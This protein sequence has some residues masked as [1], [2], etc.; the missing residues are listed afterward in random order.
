MLKICRRCDQCPN[1]T[2]HWIDYVG[3]IDIDS[4]SHSCKHCDA[5]GIECPACDGEGIVT[6][7][8]DGQDYENECRLCD[9]EGVLLVRFEEEETNV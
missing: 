4:T 2:H 5:V 3:E 8:R 6:L 1:S 9:G 7:F